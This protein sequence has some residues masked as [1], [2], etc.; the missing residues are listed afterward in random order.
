MSLI[1]PA[2]TNF[3][4]NTPNRSTKLIKKYLIFFCFAIDARFFAI[5][6]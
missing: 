1:A 4:L 6:K 2:G 3:D 5:K